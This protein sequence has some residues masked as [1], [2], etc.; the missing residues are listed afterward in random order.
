MLSAVTW[1]AESSCSVLAPT[2]AELSII[3][4]IEAPISSLRSESDEALCLRAWP[5]CASSL[6][7]AEEPSTA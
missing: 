1:T 5:E 4:S 2:S 6:N 7:E 3:D